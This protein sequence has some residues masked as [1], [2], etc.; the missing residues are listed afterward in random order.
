M[1]PNKK[2]DFLPSR[3]LLPLIT[4]EARFRDYERLLGFSYVREYR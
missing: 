4:E 2:N 1:Q 3:A